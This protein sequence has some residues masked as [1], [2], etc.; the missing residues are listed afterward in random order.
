MKSLSY[1]ALGEACGGKVAGEGGEAQGVDRGYG[2]PQNQFIIS[3]NAFFHLLDPIDIITWMENV[4]YT[5]HAFEELCTKKV[6]M[7]KKK[8]NLYVGMSSGREKCTP[9]LFEN[10]YLYI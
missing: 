5:W 1:I 8:F 6:R 4:F 7:T 2:W 9:V 3:A 10:F